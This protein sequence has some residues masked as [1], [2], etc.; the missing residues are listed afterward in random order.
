MDQPSRSSST[1]VPV[2]MDDGGNKNPT[3]LVFFFC[4]FWDGKNEGVC[5]FLFFF[6]GGRWECVFSRIPGGYHCWRVYTQESRNV[7]WKCLHPKRNSPNQ[8]DAVST[9]S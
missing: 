3:A 6:F 7:T 5:F 4:C 2:S 9:E 8:N 1:E